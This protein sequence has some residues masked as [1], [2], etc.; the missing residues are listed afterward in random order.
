MMSDQSGGT[1][2][3]LVTALG[4]A[5]DG[6]IRVRSLGRDLTLY[7]QRV[8]AV[9][10]LGHPHPLEFEHGPDEL[11]VRLPEGVPIPAMPVLRVSPAES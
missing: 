2:A 4:G 7:N 10:L 6:R 9:H 1:T 8:G 11:M 5:A 3:T